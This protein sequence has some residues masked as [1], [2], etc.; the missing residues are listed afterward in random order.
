VLGGVSANKQHSDVRNAWLIWAA[1]FLTIAVMIFTGNTRVSIPSY[2]TAASNWLA[3]RGLYDGTGVG[4]FVYLPQA[5]MLFVPFSLLPPAPC[6]TLWRVV[7][8]GVFALGLRAFSRIAG[9]RSGA[10]LFPLMTLITAPFAWDCAR[11]GQATLA[12]TGLMLLAASDMAVGRR[13]R[14]ALW[15]SL[16]VA[17]KPLSLAM[18]LLVV[19]GER[20]MIRPALLGLAA[21]AVA[22]FLL[23]PADYVLSQY[24]A[25]FQ[26]A[27]TAAHVGVVSAGWSTPFTAL[28]IAGL[29]TPEGVQT[30]IRVAAAAFTLLLYH[31]ARKRFDPDYAMVWL[32][33]LSAVYI[34]LFSP[35]TET[36]TYALLGPA[37]AGFLA[38]AWLIEKRRT[39]AVLLACLAA[40][41]TGSAILQRLLAPHAEAIWL[42]PLMATCF[43]VY[44]MF[45]LL[46]TA[47]AKR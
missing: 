41:T 1:L 32:F 38:R 43:A 37:V 11:N 29:D 31:I 7:N 44:L 5:A 19:A 17:V 23:K 25:F 35:R 13:L 28:R 10:E 3:G 30:A 14:A 46:T 12:M 40:A 39:E 8:I 9:G 27:T 15:L 47:S 2:W 24:L 22:P 18:L 20:R 36:V 16:G 4:G 34:I 26:N 33:S 45:R 21:V 6:E 42:P